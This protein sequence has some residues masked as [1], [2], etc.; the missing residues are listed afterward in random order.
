MSPSDRD[1]PSAEAG[2]SLVA[3]VRFHLVRWLP[4][5]GAA[6]VGYLVFPPPAVAAH[7]IATRDA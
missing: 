2:R 6:L 1:L 5:V 3:S 7:A 4:L